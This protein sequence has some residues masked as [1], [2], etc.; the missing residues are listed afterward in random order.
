MAQI[1]ILDDRITN[2]R[3]LSRLAASVE[4]E[5][6]VKAF[7]DPLEALSWLETHEADLVITDF[8]MPNL[9]G[10]EVTRRIR[11][12]PHG[13]DVPVVVVTVYDDR[14]FR[15]LALEAGATDFLLAPVDH[16]EFRTR[17]RNL[18]AL[19]RHQLEARRQAER[20]RQDLETSERLR[21]A[22]MQESREALAQLIDTVP[23]MISAADPA[24]RVLFVNAQQAAFAG[25]TPSELIGQGAEAAFGSDRAAFSRELDAEVFARGEALPGFEESATAADGTA[26]E[27]FTTKAPLRDVEGRVVAVLTTS[28]DI[29]DRKRAEQRLLH[30]AQHDPVTALPN[31]SYLAERL[32]ERCAHG[33]RAEDSFALHFLDL[34]RFKAV[35]DA[36]GHQAGDR[37]LVQAARRLRAAVREGDIV[38][39]LGGDEFAI[40]QPDAASASE[41]AHLAERVISALAKPFRVAGRSISLSASVGV[42]LFPK[43]ATTADELLRNADL[44]MYR[45]K[46]AG[47]NRFGFFD[48]EMDAAAQRAMRLE[49]ELRR[50][51]ARREFELVWQPQVSLR[52]GRICGAEALLRWR[53]AARGIVSPAEF[54]QLAEETGLIAPITEWALA[55]ACSQ[56]LAWMRRRP[57]GVRISVNLSPSLFVSRDVREL[58]TDAL[59]VSGFDPALL[60]I[61]ITER[62]LLDKVEEMAATL[63]SLR[64][65][66]VSFSIDDFGTGY[67]SLAHARCFPVQR[68]KVDQAFVARVASDKA[69]AAVIGAIVSLAHGLGRDAVAEGVETAEQLAALRRL[70]CDEVQG[71]FVREPVTA[72]ELEAMLEADM[73][74]LGAG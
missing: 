50:A 49:G 58:V 10:A 65:I 72:A 42:T 1:L 44:A 60:D 73:V 18:L 68:L 15:L 27:L 55:A 35:N 30:L 64:E 13:A 51:L 53:H 41:A 14:Q 70:G 32:R 62:V 26:A 29:T 33:R 59:A 25:K 3:I 12:M 16:V 48:P 2:Q 67:S 34:D 63:Q 7:G 6:E 5:A 69:D 19:R 36:L 47:R 11:Q 74:L 39:R 9:D 52:T 17:V 71:Y 66:G 21:S 8:K 37:L 24:G 38:A 61:E 46:A 40:L 43:D 56:G 22:L 45:A 4:P 31:R 23:A 20:L 57:G 54:L 28:I